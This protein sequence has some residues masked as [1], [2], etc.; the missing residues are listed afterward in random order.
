[1]EKCPTTCPRF[2]CEALT[3]HFIQGNHKTPLVFAAQIAYNIKT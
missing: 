2:R 1:M 3:K